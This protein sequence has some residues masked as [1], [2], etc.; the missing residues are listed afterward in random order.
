M[1]GP[2]DLILGMHA[3]DWRR[4]ALGFLLFGGSG[5]LLL[6][7]ASIFGVDARGSVRQWLLL[8]AQSPFA[9]LI[10]VGAFALLAFLGVP[11]VV[12]IAAA[13]VAF[14]PWLGAAYSWIGTMVS[15]TVGF[16]LGRLGGSRLL[17]DS[18]GEGLKRFIA[19]IGRNGFLASLVVRVVPSVPFVVVNMA[20]GVTR[21]R[22]WMFAAGT[23]IG[24]LPKILLTALA[25]NSLL[26]GL[27]GQGQAWIT[28]GLLA[29]VI[30]IWIA[31][32][33]MARRWV[34]QRS[35]AAA[36]EGT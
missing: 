35:D 23:A 27:T 14:G 15:A 31:A 9:L 10:V 30:A 2:I 33:F 11:Q 19:M 36:G 29:A 28:V 20:A 26:K 12:L 18:G 5:L 6:G 7:A 22:F 1:R 21:M 34:A 8:A 17:R 4:L 13:A 32:G 24:V 3:R 25:G 16:W